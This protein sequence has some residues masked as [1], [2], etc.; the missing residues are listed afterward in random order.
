MGASRFWSAIQESAVARELVTCNLSD[1]TAEKIDWIWPG[2]IA[3]GKLTLLAGEPGL[4][5]S[6]VTLYVA[7]T[8][9][10]GTQWV[11][12]HDRARR[13]R[14]LMLSAEDGLA[15]TVRPRFDA[16]GGDPAMVRIIRATRTGPAHGTF[17]LAADLVLLERE[18]AATWRRGARDYRSDLI[19]HAESG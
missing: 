15:D 11:A 8:I 10:R 12:S 13:G 7:S 1:V 19:L 16:A 2:R 9:T 3:V 5:K 4:G 14:V 18:I 6:Q 17:N